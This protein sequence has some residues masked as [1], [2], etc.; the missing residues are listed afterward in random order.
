M[1]ARWIMLKIEKRQNQGPIHSPTNQEFAAIL[2]N[3]DK[4][5]ISKIFWQFRNGTTYLCI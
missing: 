2:S 3:L 1:L 5:P 4:I